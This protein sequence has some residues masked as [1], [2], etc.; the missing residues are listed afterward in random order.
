MPKAQRCK[1]TIAY[2]K[3]F[4]LKKHVKNKSSS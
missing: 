4:I 1:K 2:S 3:V